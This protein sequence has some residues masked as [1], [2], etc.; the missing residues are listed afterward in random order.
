[1]EREIMRW[2]NELFYSKR[3]ICGPLAAGVLP[4]ICPRLGVMWS[5]KSS[6][7]VS[8]GAAEKSAAI[9]KQLAKSKFALSNVCVLTPYKN[10]L[11]AI[12]E[13]IK[14]IR[15]DYGERADC[16]TIDSV[17]GREYLVIIIVLPVLAK[18]VNAFSADWRRVNVAITRARSALY[19]I[20]ER[21]AYKSCSGDALPV[22]EVLLEHFAEIN[23]S[24]IVSGPMPLRY[25]PTNNAESKRA[26][27]PE[28]EIDVTQLA[29]TKS[30]AVMQ[31][32]STSEVGDLGDRWEKWGAFEVVSVEEVCGE[33][34]ESV[35]GGAVEDNGEDVEDYPEWEEDYNDG[36][37][38]C[39]QW[40]NQ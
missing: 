32:A 20:T 7:Y 36:E 8:A 39:G 23:P 9:I 1:M 5:G 10:Q 2:S 13:A 37:E 15:D 25:L 19:V 35:S 29:E 40:K 17:Q 3:L 14:E 28:A 27:S 6:Y 21:E 30:T 38:E 22:W 24:Q 26:I 16:C 34:V 12:E 18:G 11:A 4:T 33:D 31:A